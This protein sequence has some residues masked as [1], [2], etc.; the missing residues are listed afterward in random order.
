MEDR[1]LAS[2]KI[3]GEWCKGLGRSFSWRD[4]AGAPDDAVEVCQFCVD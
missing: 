1:A 2:G 4:Y 3:K